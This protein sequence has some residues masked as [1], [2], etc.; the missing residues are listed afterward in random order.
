MDAAIWPERGPVRYSRVALFALLFLAHAALLWLMQASVPGTHRPGQEAPLALVFLPPPIRSGEAAHRR[1]A[2]APNARA[3]ERRLP[4]TPAAPRPEALTLIPPRIDWSA[5]ADIVAR[6]QSE[7]ANAPQPRSLDDHHRHSEHRDGVGLNSHSPP[8][9]GW[10]DAAIHRFD[11]RGGVPVIHLSD[12]CVIA[13]P[14]GPY[15]P[16]PV[17]G[18]GKK[19]EPRGDLFEHMRDEPQPTP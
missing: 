9:F 14:L 18:F 12:R 8:E 15:L 11:T 13:V 19:I 10:H 1:A 3:R 17:C 16:L 6:Q 2:A 7:L 5:E 4:G